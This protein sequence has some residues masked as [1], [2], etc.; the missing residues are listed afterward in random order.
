MLSVSLNKPNK[1]ITV[2]EVKTSVDDPKEKVIFNSTYSDLP[3]GTQYASKTVL[4]APEKDLRIVIE[5][6]GF[7]NA[8]GK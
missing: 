3:D 6:S 8:V 2:V 1:K 4:D 7:K 5:N